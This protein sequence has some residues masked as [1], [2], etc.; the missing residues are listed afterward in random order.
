MIRQTRQFL[1]R[2]LAVVMVAL[3]LVGAVLPV[4]PTVPFLLVAAWAA[5]RGW[6]SLERWLL[7]HPKY[8]SD[9]RRWRERGA[10]PR[11]AKWFAT[12]MM[13]A[14]AVM[15]AFSAAPLWVRLGVP[16]MMACVALWLWLRPEE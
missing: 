6:P 4:L 1:W 15:L 11:K 9:I 14:S 16:A 10:V 7:T 12:V 8:G 13:M 3:G 5:S 2:L